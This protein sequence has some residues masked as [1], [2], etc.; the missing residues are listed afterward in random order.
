VDRVSDSDSESQGFDSL[1]AYG[2]SLKLSKACKSNLLFSGFLMLLLI[3]CGNDMPKSMNYEIRA[4]LERK[5][6]E[7]SINEQKKI[8]MI[9]S[10]KPISDNKVGNKIKLPT[11]LQ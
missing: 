4:K 6:I 3:K 8:K 11:L 1:H 10:P 9:F 7:S 2:S 5:H